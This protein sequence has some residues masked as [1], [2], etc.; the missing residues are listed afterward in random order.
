M[1]GSP[2][3]SGFQGASRMASSR[4]SRGRLLIYAEHFIC[5][6]MDNIF[7]PWLNKMSDTRSTIH[8]IPSHPFRPQQRSRVASGLWR[9]HEILKEARYDTAGWL[10]RRQASTASGPWTVGPPARAKPKPNLLRLRVRVDYQRSGSRVLVVRTGQDR[11]GQDRTGQ[12][13]QGCEGR[14]QGQQGSNCYSLLPVMMQAPR[15]PLSS[16]YQSPSK[17]TLG[18]VRISSESRP[19]AKRLLL[20]W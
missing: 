6:Q 3:I 9:R 12:A 14:G 5:K 20:L 10:R 1:A 13:G 19:L 11:T 15:P 7:S 8:A 17:P 16:A 18:L 4:R 2:A